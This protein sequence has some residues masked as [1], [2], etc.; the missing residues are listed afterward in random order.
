MGV[1]AAPFKKPNL[2]RI[3]L[4]Q[5]ALLTALA[6]LAAPLGA[7]AAEALKVPFEYHKLD[8]GLKVVLSKDTTAPTVAVTVYYH[9]GF[10]IEPRDRTG[11]AHPVRTPDVP[12]VDQPREARV[13]QAGGEERGV[14]NG[15]TRFDFTNYYQ[16]VPANTVETVLW[17][18]ADRMKGLAI[19]SDNLKSTSRV[20]SRTRCGSTCSTSPTAR[21]PGSTCP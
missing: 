11:F 2:R 20:W 13:R 5:T 1:L 14:L 21:S 9:I 4:R 10:R 16:V 12:G 19:D 6:L 8:N 15:S 18:E 17:A 7:A 3:P